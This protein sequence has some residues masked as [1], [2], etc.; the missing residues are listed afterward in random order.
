MKNILNLFLSFCCFIFF[1]FGCKKTPTS[2]TEK[3]EVREELTQNRAISLLNI[4]DSLAASI[5]AEQDLNRSKES[6]F[7]EKSEDEIEYKLLQNHRYDLIKGIQPPNIKIGGHWGKE[8]ITGNFTGIN[9]DTIWLEEYEFEI[10]NITYPMYK[11]KSNIPNFPEIEMYWRSSGTAYIINEG[12]MDGDGKDE[13][14]WMIGNHLADADLEYHI[15]RYNDNGYW[16]ELVDENGNPYEFSGEERHSGIDFFT[17]G[18]KK[19]TIII[20]HF[21]WPEEPGS[22][23]EVKTII[24]NPRWQKI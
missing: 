18:P 12:D 7:Q 21:Y 19:G 17:K 2:E 24:D 3:R 8:V 23:R 14:G 5:T 11:V 4:M 15:V 13:W 6:T 16:E 10:D 1:L 9:V 20:S 22:Q